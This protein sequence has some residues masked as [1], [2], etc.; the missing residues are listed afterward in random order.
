MAEQVEKIAS[1][2]SQVN[3]P[4]ETIEF[5]AGDCSYRK[6]YRIYSGA[7]TFVLM[8]APPQFEKPKQF[9]D[10]ACYLN[11][12]GLRTPKIFEHCYQSGFLIIEDF[13]NMTFT[14]S[15]EQGA[16]LETLLKL[17]IDA[18]VT[19]HKK[20]N[21]VP[22]FIPFYSQSMW[23]EEVS[24]F[25]NWHFPI[26]LGVEHS[27][28]QIEEYQILWA[29]AY[30]SINQDA[31][32]LV[33]RD[34]HVDNVMLLPHQQGVT[35]C[36]L[37]DFQDAVLGSYVYDIVSLLQDARIDVPFELANQCIEYYLSHFENINYD[38]F[39]KSYRI[40]GA[41]RGLKILEL[42]TRLAVTAF[43]EKFLK[44]LP[45]LQTYLDYNF[46][47]SSL[48]PLANWFEQFTPLKFG[49]ELVDS[50]QRK[51]V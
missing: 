23:I 31:K 26:H 7:K 10:V 29:Q 27:K 48:V 8:D 33:L 49:V 43:N 5:L 14:K 2:L 28:E 38:A 6:Y 35:S 20:V 37:L 50:D 18:L 40:I 25:F 13:G 51:V 3:W 11:S 12:L 22:E 39:M 42:F 32:T 45:R 9:V 15:L 4:F 34:Y 16:S 1:F 17:A 19:L 30:D 36:G 46:T 41:Q 44:C 24:R 47:E 21:S